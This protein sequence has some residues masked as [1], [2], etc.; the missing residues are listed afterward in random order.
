[1][2]VAKLGYELNTGY[3]PEDP[4]GHWSSIACLTRLSQEVELDGIRRSKIEKG[5]RVVVCKIIHYE[6][7]F[8]NM[9]PQAREKEQSRAVKVAII[10][11]KN[12]SRQAGHLEQKIG[13]RVLK[14]SHHEAQT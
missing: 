1:M 5:D 8:S 14:P 11:D 13:K 2:H 6:I 4:D 10:V 3:F 7:M 9:P 12:R